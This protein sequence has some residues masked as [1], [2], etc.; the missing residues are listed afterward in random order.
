[1][2]PE[3]AMSRRT[4]G[5]LDFQRRVTIP[6]A[7]SHVTWTPSTPRW[8]CSNGRCCGQAGHRRIRSCG[9]LSATYEARE[10]GVRAA[11]SISGP[12][13]APDAR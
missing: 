1:M 13:V 4:T 12:Q 9:S 7:R 8:N 5:K 2:P 10:F 3:A 6:H 11:M